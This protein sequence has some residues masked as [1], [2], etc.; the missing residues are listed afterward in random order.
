MIDIV[1]I[2]PH[3]DALF[4][5]GR[6]GSI[7]LGWCARRVTQ[8]I[9]I[10]FSFLLIAYMTRIQNREMNVESEVYMPIFFLSPSLMASRNSEVLK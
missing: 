7:R 1:R 4:R 10:M 2:S 9:A 6:Q 8:L 5:P 3:A